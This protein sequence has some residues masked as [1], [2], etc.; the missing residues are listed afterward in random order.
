L[1][2]YSRDMRSVV[3]VVLLAIPAC[4]AAVTPDTV[5]SSTER[6]VALIQRSQKGWFT[7]QSC[8]SC[9]Q[10]ILPTL[11]FR[12]ARAHGVAVNEAAARDDAAHAFSVY[13]NLDRAV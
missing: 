3:A 1:L 4:S 11:A 7:K 8:A 13:A 12:D 10:Q 5:R 9:H 2:L 6:A